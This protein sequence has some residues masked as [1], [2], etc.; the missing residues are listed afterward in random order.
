VRFALAFLACVALTHGV[1]RGAEI[2]ATPIPDL[3]DTAMIT[4][5]GEMEQSDV[6]QFRA[7][8]A[9][10]PKAFIAFQSPGGSL[11]AGI[12]I[13]LQI[14]LRNYTT[15]V[16]TGVQC[17]SACALA[18]LG[19]TKR[20][21]GPG[22]RIGFHA[23]SV[24][25][26]ATETGEGNALLGAYLNKLG[27]PDRAVG[28][29]THAHPNEITWLTTADAERKGIDVSLFEAPGEETGQ[30][31]PAPPSPAPPPSIVFPIP[32]PP[33]PSSGF[34]FPDS[35][36]WVLSADEVA[37]LSPAELSIARN[38]IFARR[39]RIF[40]SPDLRAYFSRF[41]WYQPRASEVALN[42]VESQNVEIIQEAEGPTPLAPPPPPS[43]GFIFP[44]SDR[45]VLSPDEVAR[46]SPAELSIAR[47]EIF[48]RRGRIFNSPD[49]RAYFSKFQWYQ[50]RA[51][52]VTLN[53]VE[54]QNVE[55][56]RKA[57]QHR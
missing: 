11:S 47:N 34:I 3:P 48:A 52:E 5:S 45:R 17:A 18:W 1:A 41:P 16:P 51:S 14:R 56:I 6:E 30:V 4:L 33:P 8:A 53:A 49:L 40:N 2:K 7:A 57:E 31:P 38:E 20:L 37:R 28:Y 24:S 26:Q 10:Y 32:P 15:L 12:D 19:G 21:M 50:P 55:I 29:I 39:G 9:T 54:G 43:S 44:D 42:A 35:D 27:L 46:L 13:G 23:A 25:G 22:A 36:R